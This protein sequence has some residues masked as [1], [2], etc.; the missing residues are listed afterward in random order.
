[1][2]GGVMSAPSQVAGIVP[3]F[4]LDDE[5]EV[6]NAAAFYGSLAI[7]Q[8]MAAALNLLVAPLTTLVFTHLYVDLRVR[9][10]GLD[11]EDRFARLDRGTSAPPPPAPAA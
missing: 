5:G 7:S 11:F 3:W 2:L 1:V 10:E 8:V 4:F 9:R 6:A